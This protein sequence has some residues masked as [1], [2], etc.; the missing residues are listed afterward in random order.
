MPRSIKQLIYYEP[1]RK[2]TRPWPYRVFCKVLK[3]RPASKKLSPYKGRLCKNHLYS[4]ALDYQRTKYIGDF[5]K[6]LRQNSA[7]LSESARYLA[8]HK[9]CQTEKRSLQTR[10]EVAKS[11]YVKFLKKEKYG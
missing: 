3:V 10:D 9:I 7:S 11:N 4:Q 8:F 2:F 1:E 5:D 6:E